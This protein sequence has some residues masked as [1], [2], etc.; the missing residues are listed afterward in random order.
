MAFGECTGD[1][2]PLQLP[3]FCIALFFPALACDIYVLQDT[4]MR[5]S[6]GWKQPSLTA[7]KIEKKKK[8]L[9]IFSICSTNLLLFLS[10]K[11]FP[12]LNSPGACQKVHWFDCMWKLPVLW[13]PMQD[14]RL[15]WPVVFFK[16]SLSCSLL[17][18]FM[19][20]GVLRYSGQMCLVGLKLSQ[21][22]LRL[23]WTHGGI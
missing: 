16:Q 7:S 5:I 17:S 13:L 1:S 9:L 6:K 14:K 21:Q 22:Q 2:I 10:I 15:K 18:L 19:P 11:A 8:N 23:F 4:E 20:L 3:W 12:L